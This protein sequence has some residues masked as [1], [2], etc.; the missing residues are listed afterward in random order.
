[1]SSDY[2]VIVISTIK[3]YPFGN[4]TTDDLL[5]PGNEVLASGRLGTPFPFLGQTHSTYFVSEVYNSK[6]DNIMY[7]TIHNAHDYYPKQ[8]SKSPVY[9]I[10]N[11]IHCKTAGHCISVVMI[12]A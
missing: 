4:N 6:K 2:A 12:T 8:L 1:M 3:L 5:P 10:R 11:K 9:S 7:R